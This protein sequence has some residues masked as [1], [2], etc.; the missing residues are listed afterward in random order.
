MKSILLLP[1]G[2]VDRGLVEDLRRPLASEF[3]AT[4]SVDSRMLDP[5]FAFHIERQQYHSTELVDTLR[6]FRT[7]DAHVVGIT[8]VDLF[9]PILTFVFGEAE[10]HGHCAIASYH[11]LRQEFYGLEPDRAIL[12]DRLV[13]EAVHETGHMAGLTH[14]ENYE[15]AMATSHGV[16]WI[17]LKGRTLCNHC[18]TLAGVQVKFAAY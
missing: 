11:R 8:A 7:G 16:E 2:D 14:C 12:L 15:C 5:A 6:R 18:R 3:L 1:V 17:D 13:K 4:V 9:I 10:L